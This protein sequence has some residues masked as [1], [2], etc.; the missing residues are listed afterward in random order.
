MRQSLKF[1]FPRTIAV[2]NLD[3]CM[4]LKQVIHD[5]NLTKP[6]FI[7]NV[8][9]GHVA[10]I[11]AIQSLVDDGNEIFK[12]ISFDLKPSSQVSKQILLDHNVV[13]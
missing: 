9:Y 5:C 1:Y 2:W 8:N 10:K 13:K 7:T 4:D 11:V 6:N 12:N 3:E